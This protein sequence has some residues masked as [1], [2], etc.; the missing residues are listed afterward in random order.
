M[1]LTVAVLVLSLGIA[2]VAAGGGVEPGLAPGNYDLELDHGG[3]VRRFLTHV[4]PQAS[5]GLPL[6]VVLSFHGG[7]SSAKDH[8]QWCE[9]DRVADRAGFVVVYPDGTGHFGRN[10]LTW[11]AGTCCG[12]AYRHEVDDVGFALAVLADLAQRT[13]IDHTRVYATG[14]SNGAMMSYR[15]A[16]EASDRIAAIAPVAGGMVVES[17]RPTRP[18]PVMHFH[19]ID[20]HR[21][22]YGGGR[23]PLLPFFNRELH[24]G[25]QETIARWVRND[26][27]PPEAREGVT[28]QVPALRPE[29]SH[30]AQEF[31]HAPCWGGVE[32]ILWKLTGAGHVWPGASPRYSELLLGRPTRVIDASETMWRFFA[33]FSRPDAPPPRR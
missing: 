14:M 32:V 17:F 16:A 19:S 25:V 27:C 22:P 12:Y 29:E 10:L 8:Q 3:R 28:I 13:R 23:G 21:A 2:P 18:V 6:P 20:D 9:L 31:I 30:V 1:R 15:L 4:P 5:R 26:G 24:P 11:N 7:G 33:K